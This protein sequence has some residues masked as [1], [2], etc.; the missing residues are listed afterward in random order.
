MGRHKNPEFT[1]Y[2]EQIVFPPTP[3][4][5]RPVVG[6]SGCL[7]FLFLSALF[8]WI[9]HSK[10]KQNL[11]ISDKVL[12]GFTFCI[13][14]T[15]LI[16]FTTFRSIRHRAN[17]PVLHLNEQ[18]MAGPGTLYSSKI[19]TIAY[20]DITDVYIY[21]TKKKCGLVVGTT[22]QVINYIGDC[23]IY[24]SR[25][26]L[27]R[28]RIYHR[29]S[30][31]PGGA[32]R[33]SQ[34]ERNRNRN[35]QL[36][37]KKPIVTN[38]L[39]ALII[40]IFV[41]ENLGGALTN[42]FELFR[43]GA[44]VRALVLDGEW[45]RL[46]SGNFLH[47]NFVH[48]YFNGMVLHSLGAT[49]EKLIGKNR[50]LLVYMLSALS[51]S[52]LSCIFPPALASVGASTAIFGII[53][54]LLVLHIKFYDTLPLMLKQSKKWWIFIA[55]LNIGLPFFIPEIDYAA[56]IGGFIAGA[57]LALQ[58]YKTCD[59]FSLS[60]PP[61]SLFTKVGVSI[62]CIVFIIGISMAVEDQQ[63]GNR[64]E[65]KTKFVKALVADQKT[66]AAVLN[67]FAWK[68]VTDSRATQDDLAIALSA[69][70]QAVIK[71]PKQ[72][73]LIDTLAT[74]YYRLA[75]YDK[76]VA[77]ERKAMQLKP[78]NPY[79]TQLACFLLANYRTSG[80]IIQGDVPE[81]SVE[82][83]TAPES[84]GRQLKVTHD[85]EHG[86]RLYILVMN[87]DQLHGLLQVTTGRIEKNADISI[88]DFLD[89]HTDIRRQNYK[90]TIAV[91]DSTQRVD[92]GQQP[93]W[94]YW[95]ADKTIFSYKVLALAN[96]NFKK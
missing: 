23:N 38:M 21:K 54:A 34:I 87:G 5:I 26:L 39:L 18:I 47:K 25:F 93:K 57:V 4:L 86:I 80:V 67:Y 45:F 78:I 30:A 31:L 95:L 72:P 15:G 22:S 75:T 70:Q 66:E 55:G 79:A 64:Q 8:I 68:F 28:K 37:I 43:W 36:L 88:H 2:N 59:T 44:N 40:G 62:T 48:I 32:F 24:Y 89:K 73:E 58:F 96:S 1:T 46:I 3:Y 74:A 9:I 90:L 56:H 27:L 71:R 6:I 92:S 52:I 17:R 91:I 13:T 41:L 49:L 14:I 60:R 12:P 63:N 83:I 7:I 20:S 61:L 65:W 69:S 81:K 53:G 19:K 42:S 35:H 29:L 85:F 11:P 76:A 77:L 84:G 51:G 94:A 10:L 50:F 33:L 82:M 16:F